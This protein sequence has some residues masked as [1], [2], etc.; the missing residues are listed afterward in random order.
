[1]IQAQYQDAVRL[2]IDNLYTEYVDILATR[3]TV[4]E[5]KESLA[6]L[7]R[8]P[9]AARPGAAAPAGHLRLEIQREAAEVELDKAQE[10][11]RADLNTLGALLRM[12][13]AESE[14]LQVR[15][16]LHDTAPP[17]TSLDALLRLALASRPD[18]VAF[19]L[20][21]GRA[22]ADVRLALA[23]RYPDLFVLYQPYTF[24]DNSPI[25]RKSAHSWGVGVAVP[26]PVFNR[27][28]GNIQRARLNVS[29]S[30]ADLAALEDQVVFEVRQAERY[31]A[32]TRAAV[33]RIE[34][35]LLPKARQEHDRVQRLYLAGRASELAFLTAERDY[36]LIVRQY[37]DALV[38][39]RR[40]ML[41]LNT[42]VGQRVLP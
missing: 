13:P 38:Q 17:P 36:G 22:E 37:R 34:R 30:Q 26:I 6:E 41:K 39:H 3:E 33:G 21:L 28:Q 5:A 23:N 2:Q 16:S 29:Q 10:Q 1:V 15:G 24:Q 19:R 12:T 8:P 25:G 40:S 9:D 27:N 32:V 11:A 42:A 18:L 31:Y 4:L 14:R 35:S 7:A 20:G